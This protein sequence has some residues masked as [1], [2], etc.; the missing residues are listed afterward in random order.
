MQKSARGVGVKIRLAN[1]G[2]GIG[3]SRVSRSDSA[4]RVFIIKGS[5]AKFLHTAWMNAVILPMSVSAKDQ[6]I[7]DLFV[8]EV[9]KKRV[10]FVPKTVGVRVVIAFAGTIRS[11][12]RGRGNDEFPF[13]TA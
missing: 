13:R 11:D 1:G 3:G 9:L 12:E 8:G 7:L 2:L 6:D 5:T 10:C 4:N